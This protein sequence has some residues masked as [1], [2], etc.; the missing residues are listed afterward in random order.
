M[1]LPSLLKPFDYITVSQIHMNFRYIERTEITLQVVCRSIE[2]AGSR[3][4]GEPA[5][6]AFRSTS[7]Q[8]LSCNGKPTG[9]TLCIFNSRLT[10]I[11]A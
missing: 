10:R 9:S 4:T 5:A 1:L 8:K 7:R 6:L 2:I 3:P 11:I